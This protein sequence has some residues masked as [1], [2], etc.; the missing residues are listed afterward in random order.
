M[1]RIHYEDGLA[2][3]LKER[4]SEQLEVSRFLHDTIAQ[5]LIALSFTL[6]RLESLALSDTARAE[7]ESAVGLIDGC[8]RQA[9]IIDVMMASPV[10]DGGAPDAAIEHLAELL[11]SE[12]GIPI[13]LDLDPAKALS[14]EGQVLLLAVVRSWFALVVRHGAKSAIF[15]RLRNRQMIILDIE[16]S[17]APPGNPD[18]W[19]LFTG[20]ARALGGEF[21]VQYNPDRL[22]AS[23]SLPADAAE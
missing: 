9:R 5:D 1:A 10:I 17:P 21:A 2:A 11:R 13:T 3:I 7:V 6:S 15:I 23:L 20:C 4:I 22:A 8:C 12:T 16:I 14:H 19:T 18:G